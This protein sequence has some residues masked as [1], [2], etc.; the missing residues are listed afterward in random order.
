MKALMATLDTLQSIGQIN[1]DASN[2]QI[3]SIQNVINGIVSG[4]GVTGDTHNGVNLS[5]G[6][7]D[8]SGVALPN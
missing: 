2:N 3:K 8:E 1:V 5:G 7:T 6:S 4:T